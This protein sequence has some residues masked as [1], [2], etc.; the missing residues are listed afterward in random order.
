[1]SI[2]DSA[3]DIP[4]FLY[5]KLWEIYLLT[6]QKRVKSFF[7]LIS[8]IAIFMLILIEGKPE[9]TFLSTS[10]SVKNTKIVFP[11][12]ILILSLRYFVLSALSLG[13]RNKFNGWFEAYKDSFDLSNTQ[14]AK[15]E[16][17]HLKSDDVNELP[18]M[19][20][21]PIQID[22]SNKINMSGNLKK[23]IEFVANVVFSVFH[24]SAIVLYTYL[25]ICDTHFKGSIYLLTLTAILI[26]TIIYFLFGISK[27]RKSLLV[28]GEKMNK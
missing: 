26:L 23:L 6:N 19:F 25:F 14:F 4:T 16:F 2:I 15:F 24:C 22:K 27:A 3:K 5:Q 8:V 11:L 18:N 7:Y 20:L 12:F 17:Q 21:I 9:V 1:M 10:I 13:N 28:G